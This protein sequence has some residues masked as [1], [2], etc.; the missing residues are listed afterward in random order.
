MNTPLCDFV[1]EYRDRQPLRLHMPGH[2]GLGKDQWADITE[3]DGADVLYHETG[4]L[5]QSEQ[6]AA[7]LFGAGRTL[8]STEGSSLC[9]RAMVYLAR[10][11]AEKNGKT[12]RILAARNAHKT[13]INAAALMDVDVK[14]LCPN[15]ATLLS[16]PIMPGALRNE[17]RRYA[18]TA[19]YI[20]S[21]DYLGHMAD[22]AA[23]A[24]VCRSMGVLL[25]V[26]NAHGA[27]LKF[28]PE[29]RH[30]LDLGA[31]IC[32][33]SAHK[34]LPVLTGGA[35]L[36]IAGDPFLM[37][38]AAQAMALFA[39]TSPSYL[40]L[41]SLDRVN[42]ILKR[43]FPKKLEQ[44]VYVLDVCRNNLVQW[45]ITGDE[46]L[47]WTLQTKEMGYLGTELKDILSQSDVECEFADPDHLVM[48]FSP[49]NTLTD[50]KEL[51]SLLQSILP[52]RA[53]IG[54]PPA[55]P[56]PI[57]RIS[58]HQALFSPSETLPVSQA[59][60]R[61]L[62]SACVTCPPA[63]PVVALGEE[64]TPEAIQCMQYYG[65]QKCQVVL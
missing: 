41:Q 40:I 7:S 48:M 42:P 17:I 63:V 39:S 12:C 32:C 21:P 54:E 31:D 34:T 1:K 64:I 30:P 47:K 50:L 14:W 4:V 53:I 36:H 38:Q 9:I 58:P 19:V 25:M 23:I 35:Y 13:F 52:R 26:D 57:S 22:I 45:F 10:M 60:G 65:I 46:P 29:S 49:A 15:K 55:L 24:K 5:L 3:I 8:Y 11:Y 62:A 33:D 2:K 37:E 44:L 20:T 16:C 43:S 61:I 27:Y 59:Q 18:P 56:M 6:N 51:A 28:L